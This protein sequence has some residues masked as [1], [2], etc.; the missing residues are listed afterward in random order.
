MK[1]SIVITSEIL[2]VL[3]LF[4]MQL[5]H[6]EPTKKPNIVIIMADQQFADAMSCVMGNQYIN[7][8]QMDKLA[9]KGILFTHAYSPNPL[10]MP[11][12]TS[13]MTGRFPHETGV[14]T[15][16]D[17]DIN[18]SNF[19]FLG[20]IFK[21][22]GYE[23]GYFGKWHVAFDEKQKEI[24]GFDN[25]IVKGSQ[26]DAEP[27]AA[28]LKQKHEKPF[29]VVASFLSPHEVC[30]W[31]RRQDLPGAPISK[32]PQLEKLPPL[33]TNFFPPENET[34]I[35]TFMRKSYQANLRLFPVGDYT[36][37]DW[38]RLQW[39]YYRLIERADNFVGEV[40]E[41]LKKSGHGTGKKHVGGFSQRSRRLCR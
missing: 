18:P 31:S 1:I 32:M 9:E 8:P 20:K 36:D 39:G 7:T 41:A 5:L 19:V 23:T 38:R 15:N 27:A 21:D 35:M 37:A 26:L 3:L 25:P 12:R 28:F 4:Q 34:D 22:A 2:M 13:M 11:M 16:D 6:S 14:L 29:L 10:C 24:H 30:Q 40:M 33:K 17:K